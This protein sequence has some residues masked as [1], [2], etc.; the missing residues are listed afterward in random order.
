[1]R[2]RI[3]YN[4]VD[5]SSFSRRSRGCLSKNATPTKI[6]FP[7]YGKSRW[8]ILQYLRILANRNGNCAVSPGWDLFK[9]M[10]F[11]TTT[12]D[13]NFFS[14]HGT[15]VGILAF[16]LGYIRFINATVFSG[17]NSYRRAFIFHLL[18]GSNSLMKNE[19]GY[20]Q[21]LNLI[22]LDE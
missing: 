16:S 21:C 10:G 12:L 7:A 13:W 18:Y 11:D 3:N 5:R 4:R 15:R 19:C 1:M 8:E 2:K 6:H 20:W 22:K 14:K 9:L 17:E